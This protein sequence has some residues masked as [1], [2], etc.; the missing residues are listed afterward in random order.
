LKR[1][2]FS[3]A[4]WFVEESEKIRARMA[5]DIKAL[6]RGSGGAKNSGKALRSY[7]SVFSLIGSSNDTD[8]SGINIR[9]LKFMLKFF[10]TVMIKTNRLD[11]FMRSQHQRISEEIT[12]PSVKECFRRIHIVQ[13]YIT[14]ILQL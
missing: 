8:L 12:I 13:N 2:A 1:V 4:L 14:R 10:T 7:S 3:E 6:K 11:L 9:T 5:L